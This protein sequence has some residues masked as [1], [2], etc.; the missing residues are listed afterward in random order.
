M[1]DGVLN[2]SLLFV[3]AFPNNPFVQ[4]ETWKKMAYHFWKHCNVA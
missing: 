3:L 1:F 4:M 2:T